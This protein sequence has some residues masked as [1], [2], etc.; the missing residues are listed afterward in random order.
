MSCDLFSR[1]HGSD[2]QLEDLHGG[3]PL[4]LVVLINAVN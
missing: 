2:E 3:D 1:T 4:G